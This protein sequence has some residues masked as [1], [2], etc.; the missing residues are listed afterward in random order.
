MINAFAFV[1]P[2]SGNSGPMMPTKHGQEKIPKYLKCVHP[3]GACA[4]T[5][6]VI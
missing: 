2:D 5:K 3:Y 1:F 6:A 4:R